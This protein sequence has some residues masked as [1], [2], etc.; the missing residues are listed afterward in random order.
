MSSA[1]F[2][3]VDIRDGKYVVLS[4]NGVYIIY[5]NIEMCFIKLTSK[6]RRSPFMIDRRDHTRMMMEQRACF[7]F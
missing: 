3:I 5:S 6:C 7:A 2:C 4:A 1:A